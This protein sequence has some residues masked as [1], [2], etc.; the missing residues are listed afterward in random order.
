VAN[1]G[2]LYS[3]Y[4]DLL[5]KDK[6]YQSEANYVVS[7]IKKH[8]PAAKN[9]F[10][11]G[12]GT[13]IHASYF[14][15]AGYNVFG[16]DQSTEMLTLADKQKRKFDN[17]LEF[18]QGDIETFKSNRKFEVAL[19]LF[20]VMCYLNSNTSLLNTFKNVSEHLN[21]DGIFVFDCWY[22]PGV[23]TD[24]PAVR[25]KRLEN[26]NLEVTRIAEPELVPNE[27]VNH[28]HYSLFIK[29]KKTSHISV[30]QE[31]HS[32]RYFF[33]PEIDFLLSQAGLRIIGFYKYLTEEKPKLDTWNAVFVCKKIA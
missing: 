33:A 31:K 13:G 8:A 12:C 9:I 26:E 27:N 16:I 24:P 20:H 6:D 21:K 19:S 23:L 30:T 2:E 7:L 18:A 28:V 5:Y 4:Y 25:V 32:V 14:A 22:G 15:K 29:D 17:Q 10:E 11:L 3:Q 1:F